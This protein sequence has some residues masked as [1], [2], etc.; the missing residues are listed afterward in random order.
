MRGPTWANI[1]YLFVEAL[2]RIGQHEVAS[3]LRCKNAEL[4]AQHRDIYEYYNP[5]TG[6]RPLNAAPVFGWT[7][8]VSSTWLCRRRNWQL[9]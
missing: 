2:T 1:N 4:M 7:A 3:R 5:L 8:A 6:E 9:G